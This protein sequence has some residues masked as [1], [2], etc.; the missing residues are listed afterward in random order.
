MFDSMPKRLK[1]TTT[2]LALQILK[3]RS[4]IPKLEVKRLLMVPA[5]RRRLPWRRSHLM[6]SKRSPKPDGNGLQKGSEKQ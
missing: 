4:Y 5:N 6:T 1:G 3:M 2:Q